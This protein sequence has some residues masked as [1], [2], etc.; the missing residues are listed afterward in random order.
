MGKGDRKSTKG[1]RFRKS[2]G[3]SRPRK[4]KRNKAAAAAK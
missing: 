2:F 1:K 4:G 3:I